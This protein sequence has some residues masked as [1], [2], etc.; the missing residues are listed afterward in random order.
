MN[1]IDPY[2][3]TPTNLS[4]LALSY[5]FDGSYIDSAAG[6]TGV[7]TGEASFVA[8]RKSGKSC[9]QFTNGYVQPIN[10]VV[11]NDTDQ[12]SISMWLKPDFSNTEI[13]VISE[14]QDAGWM[15]AINEFGQRAVSAAE[16]VP[17]FGYSKY[18]VR[19]CNPLPINDGNWHHILLTIDRK[20]VAANTMK[21]YVDNV[22]ITIYTGY[23]LNSDN[24]EIFQNSYMIRCGAR[25]QN[26][27]VYKGLMSEFKV[28]KKI[29]T[30]TE[31]DA[32]YNS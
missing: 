6:N 23:N 28:F 4:K 7:L 17:G 2:I 24:S 31:R 10:P 5:D 11:L 12:L 18:L 15:I 16:Y 13:T 27:Y 9:I 1:L 19:Y 3:F 29:L 21:L 8:G 32:I 14:A 30:S 20:E 25:S 26:S 22:L